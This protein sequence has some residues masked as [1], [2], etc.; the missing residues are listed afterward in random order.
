M[1]ALFLCMFKM[2]NLFNGILTVRGE[3]ISTTEGLVVISTGTYEG[4]Q[5]GS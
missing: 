2:W 3:E 5:E 1:T 4:L